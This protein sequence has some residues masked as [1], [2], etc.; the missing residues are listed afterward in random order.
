LIS[1]RRK[2]IPAI[3]RLAILFASVPRAKPGRARQGLGDDLRVQ[4]GT[5]GNDLIRLQSLRTLDFCNAYA[6]GRVLDQR[7]IAVS[8]TENTRHHLGAVAQ[9]AASSGC[10]R[11]RRAFRKQG[12]QPFVVTI[13]IIEKVH[14]T[15]FLRDG[16]YVENKDRDLYRQVNLPIVFARVHRYLCECHGPWLLPIKL[17]AQQKAG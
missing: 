7:I 1:R 2:N 11:I 9:N 6:A 5:A 13:D 3:A 10:L 14:S 8:L 17:I 15:V 4:Y 16:G 12:I